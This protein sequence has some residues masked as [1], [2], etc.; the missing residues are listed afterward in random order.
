MTTYGDFNKGQPEIAQKTVVVFPPERIEVKYTSAELE[1]LLQQYEKEIHKINWP[2][3][4][5]VGGL[6]LAILIPLITAD[7]KSFSWISGDIVKG[8]FMLAAFVSGGFFVYYVG[9]NC[10]YL[11]RRRPL[12]AHQLV[13]DKVTQMRKQLEVEYSKLK[14]MTYVSA[15]QDEPEQYLTE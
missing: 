11:C 10:Y 4:A 8:F 1:L 15:T 7:F 12:D 13:E 5:A 6:F 2:R 14:P 9:R 3:L